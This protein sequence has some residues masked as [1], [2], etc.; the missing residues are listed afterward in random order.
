MVHFKM[1]SIFAKAFF[2]QKQFM[3]TTPSL[4]ALLDISKHTTFSKSLK[5]V[6]LGTD[7]YQATHFHSFDGPQGEAALDGLA[8]QAFLVNTGS[9]RAM[10][11]EAFR[12][13]P[14]VD[15]LDVRDYNSNTRFRDGK[16][17]CWRS[18]GVVTVKD[19][20][21]C[22]LNMHTTHDSAAT[23][24]WTNLLFQNLLLAAAEAGLQIR[25][26]E[27]IFKMS[28]VSDFALY[29][30]PATLPL[31]ANLTKVHID[32]NNSY[33]GGVV[34]PPH[35]LMK[36][37]NAV[38][39]VTWLRINFKHVSVSA[40]AFVLWLAGG[41]D[42]EANG[43]DEAPNES[44]VVANGGHGAT[45]GGDGAT[46]G[47]DEETNGGDGD[48]AANDNTAQS[49]KIPAPALAH[50]TRLELGMCVVKPST[51]E[52]LLAKF[53]NLKSLTLWRFGLAQEV[54]GMTDPVWAQ[55]LERRSTSGSKLEDLTV[56]HLTQDHGHYHD[57]PVSF[58][59]WHRPHI[60]A[61]YRIRPDRPPASGNDDAWTAAAKDIKLLV[62]VV[63]GG[64]RFVGEFC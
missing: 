9:W 37:I 14:N 5:R 55:F 15:T 58:H 63:H 3:V 27:T 45:N 50:L 31:L 53:D 28:G 43:G 40:E 29:P 17:A 18:C 2:R 4:T 1:E 46:N 11:V 61:R 16:D 48:N 44:E 34:P 30:I 24:R 62:P 36:F 60:D 33:L 7:S 47:G 59:S 25:S 56:G 21:G 10:L 12:A 52:K 26:L 23:T 20:T 35:G 32:V 51:L 57:L 19:K 39:N 22:F 54:N 42:K 49:T 64:S 6:C 8:D 41:A 38:P 13:L